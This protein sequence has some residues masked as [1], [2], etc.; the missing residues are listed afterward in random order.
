MAHAG[1]ADGGFP[2]VGIHARRNTDAFSLI[3]MKT[4]S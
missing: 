4:I 2:L 1:P 3:A